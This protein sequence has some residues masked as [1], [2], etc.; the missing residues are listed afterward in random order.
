M[1]AVEF[2]LS[3]F[4]E[5]GSPSTVADVVDKFLATQRARVAEGTQDADQ[6]SRH[7]ETLESHLNRFKARIIKPIRAVTPSE[8]DEYLSGVGSSGRTR[9]NHRRTL[10]SLWNWAKD[11]RYVG[12]D[13]RTVAQRSATPKVVREDPGIFKPEDMAKLLAGAEARLLPY[14]A[15]GAFAGLRSAELCRL[16]WSNILWDDNIIV[17]RRGVTKGQRRRTATIRPNLM[18]LL[19]PFKGK[20]GK[21]LDFCRPHSLID[22]LCKQVGVEWVNNGLRHSCISYAMALERNAAAVAEQCGNSES[23]IQRSYKA[24]VTENDAKRWFSIASL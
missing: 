1:E 17:L 13:T 4:G 21:I 19:L 11:H 7:M 22:A 20:T 14:L 6:Y 2:Y 15:I 8:L 16:E 3:H 24:L 12:A 10:I 23:E 18:E 5:Q 9:F